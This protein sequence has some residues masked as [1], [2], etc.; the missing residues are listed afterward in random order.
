MLWLY[1]VSVCRVVL[2]NRR[3]AA[4]AFKVHTCPWLIAESVHR[5]NRE[6]SHLSWTAVF[7]EQLS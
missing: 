2:L 5:G 3:D 7:M 4:E 6:S 1:R